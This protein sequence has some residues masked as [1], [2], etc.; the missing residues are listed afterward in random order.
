MSRS[1][2]AVEVIP[3]WWQV[4]TILR[5]GIKRDA[6]HALYRINRTVWTRANDTTAARRAPPGEEADAARKAW[7]EAESVVQDHQRRQCELLRDIFGNPFRQVA[8]DPR[9]RSG[10]TIELGAAICKEKAFERMPILAD[11]LMDAGCDDAVI[12]DHCRADTPHVRGCWVVDLV[13]ARE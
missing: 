3:L 2:S 1:G 8:F 7:A 9:W 6:L 13:L 12:L 10:N 4:L 5:S 11:A